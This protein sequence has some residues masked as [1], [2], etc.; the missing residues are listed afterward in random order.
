MLTLV[1]PNDRL[2]A[3]R[4]LELL[5]PRTHWYRSLW[6]LNVV[7]VLHEILEGSE[8]LRAGI[9][10]EPSLRRLGTQVRRLAGQDPGVS[11]PERKLLTEALQGIPRHEGV[12]Y[13][14]IAEL[15]ER[16]N[17]A[18]LQRWA[19]ALRSPF[20]AQP[21]RAAR[22]IASYLV[23]SG[24]SEQYL[25]AWWAHLLRDQAA[26]SLPEI[27][28]AAHSQLAR[29]PERTFKV[30]LA[31]QTAPHSSAG[32]PPGWLKAADVSSWLRRNHID[33]TG[34]RATGGGLVVDVQAKDPQAAA[35]LAATQ[36]DRIVARSSVADRKA[37]VPWTSL[38]IEGEP[39][40]FPLGLAP[41]GVRV[42]ALYRENQLFSQSEGGVDAAIELLA[43]LENST[44]SAAIAGG[45]AAIEALLAEP[46]DRAGASENLA[47]LVACSFPRAELTTLSYHAAKTCHRLA[48]DLAACSE[49]RER[50]ALIARE[51]AAGNTLNFT[52]EPDLAAVHRMKRILANPSRSLSDVQTH[53]SDSFH[54]LYRQRNLIL[55][56]GRV[57]SVALRG[58]LRTAAKLVGAGLDRVA[59]GWYVKGIRPLE[60]VAR[61]RNAIALISTD[62]PA[63]CVDLLGA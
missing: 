10:S 32:F 61:A 26:V 5:D 22:S 7:L 16:V 24:F 20:T 8:A 58:S 56:G 53:V 52:R 29:M 50:A 35:Q 55:H 15:A 11:E 21:E 40:G 31:F 33:V 2:I 25:L 49:N 54:R 3:E 59:H 18:Y 17:S 44:P 36:L 46:D 1:N 12:N 39:A 48:P 14:S 37:L 57:Q 43:H 60:L 38:W 63:A 4:V 23:D 9:L 30:L 19:H 51:I 28:E 47:W 41:R 13:H 34:V 27:C 6:S 45:W 42:K 62:D